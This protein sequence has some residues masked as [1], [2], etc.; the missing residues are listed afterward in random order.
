MANVKLLLGER[1]IAAGHLLVIARKRWEDNYRA[2]VLSDFQL[3]LTSRT[4]LTMRCG[5]SETSRRTTTTQSAIWCDSSMTQGRS[6]SLSTMLI[7][8]SR[9]TP[10]FPR[11]AFRLADRSGIV[12]EP[13][14]SNG[15][16]PPHPWPAAC[17]THVGFV[18]GLPAVFLDAGHDTRSRPG[19][20]LPYKRDLLDTRYA[21][22]LRPP[23]TSG[24]CCRRSLLGT[25]QLVALGLT[26]PSGDYLRIM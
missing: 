24:D 19:D 8:T 3:V 13:H 7:T 2:T 6:R 18:L 20:L 14:A 23:D 17:I 10:T 21:S 9:K 1:F 22:V 12:R 11:G 25:G 16:V 26:G 15:D 4:R 5:V